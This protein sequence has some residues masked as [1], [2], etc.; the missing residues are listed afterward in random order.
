MHEPT[1]QQTDA[2]A[3]KG[4]HVLAV[5]SGKGGVG[6]SNIAVNLGIALAQRGRR[7]IL[8]DMDL[9]LAN[10]DILLD[11]HAEKNL[12]DVINGRGP[13]EEA[14]IDAPGGL[15]LLPGASG[16]EQLANLNTE[17]REK[18]IEAIEGLEGQADYL[19]IDT[20]AGIAE[21]TLAIAAA[22]DDVLMVTTP[23]PTAM[24][25]AYAA[26]KLLHQRA[27]GHHIHLLVNMARNPREARQT[28]LRLSSISEGFIGEHLLREGVI[29]YHPAVGEAVRHRHPLLLASPESPPARAIN[30]IAERLDQRP[31]EHRPHHSE[32][33]FIHRLLTILGG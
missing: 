8:L 28:I 12:S 14:L 2:A 4:A 5:S 3:R 15:L 13:I 19:I 9:G 27:A 29:P 6:K 24:L 10:D 18:L 32:G 31:F 11:L 16:D 1:S 17:Q 33:G 20:G 30:T 26:I 25:D 21:N 22:A 23:E 7:V